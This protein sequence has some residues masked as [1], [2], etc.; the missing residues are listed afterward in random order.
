VKHTYEKGK[1]LT[2]A[3]MKA[4]EARLVRHSKLARWFINIPCALPE[5]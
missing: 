5:P 4:V 3:A 1:S 2:K